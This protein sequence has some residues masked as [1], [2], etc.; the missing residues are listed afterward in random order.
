M[1]TRSG[2]LASVLGVGLLVLPFDCYGFSAGQN[3]SARCATPRTA[4]C[5]VAL[6]LPDEAIALPADAVV[7]LPLPR[8]PDLGRP[9]CRFPDHVSVHPVN[10]R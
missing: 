6:I 10:C 1:I 2:F 9:A 5:T 8:P 7:P 4:P 3:T